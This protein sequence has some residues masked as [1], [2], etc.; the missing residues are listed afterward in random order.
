MP[1]IPAL[2]FNGSH[3]VYNNTRLYA[4]TAGWR[5]FSVAKDL[6]TSTN[7]LRAS[8]GLGDNANDP[9]FDLQT[10]GVS[11]NGWNFWMDFSS[12]AESGG[13]AFNSTV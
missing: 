6:R 3:E 7:Q 4:A 11:P 9:G 13:G 5:G 8:M 10:D 12:P 2:S 1:A